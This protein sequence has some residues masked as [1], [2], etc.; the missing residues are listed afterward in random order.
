MLIWNKDEVGK[1]WWS[2][3]NPDVDGDKSPVE[4]ED[5]AEEVQRTPVAAGDED[6]APGSVFWDEEEVFCDGE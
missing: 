5:A 4:E 3:A 2:P 1:V 6:D